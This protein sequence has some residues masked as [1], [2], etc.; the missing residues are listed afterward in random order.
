MA[1]HLFY[2]RPI[3]LH[4]ETERHNG[5]SDRKVGRTGKCVPACVRACVSEC[6]GVFNNS[7][8]RCGLMHARAHTRAHGRTDASLSCCCFIDLDCPFIAFIFSYTVMCGI[9]RYRPTTNSF[10]KCT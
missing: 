4:R 3:H 8:V 2:I 10:E 5:K 9:A 7:H 1:C 6:A